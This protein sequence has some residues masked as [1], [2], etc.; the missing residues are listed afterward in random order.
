MVFRGLLRFH[1]KARPA[2]EKTASK[3]YLFEISGFAD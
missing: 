3:T 1:I 2:E